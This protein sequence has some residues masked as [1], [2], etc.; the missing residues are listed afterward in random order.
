[1]I[2]RF[3]VQIIILVGVFA[4]GIYIGQTYNFE[5]TPTKSGPSIQISP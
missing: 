2:G 4:L 3:A 5:S 1:M